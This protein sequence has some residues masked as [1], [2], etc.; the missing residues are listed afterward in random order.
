MKAY[1]DGLLSDDGVASTDAQ[2]L[3]VRSVSTG[4]AIYTWLSHGLSDRG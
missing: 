3:V 2:L 1:D 4:I